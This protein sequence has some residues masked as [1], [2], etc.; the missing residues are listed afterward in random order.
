MTID[1]KR[2][3]LCDWIRNLDEEALD[4]LISEY[5]SDEYDESEIE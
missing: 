3:I 2:A 5:L 1:E 4:S